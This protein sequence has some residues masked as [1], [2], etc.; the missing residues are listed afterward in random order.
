MIWDNPYFIL[1]RYKWN[2]IEFFVQLLVFSSLYHQINQIMIIN[3]LSVFMCILTT[4]KQS[5]ILQLKSLVNRYWQDFFSDLT[6]SH[7]WKI[8]NFKVAF[9][10]PALMLRL[11]FYCIG[12]KI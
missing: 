2:D 11:N 3:L 8:A 1:N 9:T 6:F 10:K 12:K 4:V 5:V 7:Q